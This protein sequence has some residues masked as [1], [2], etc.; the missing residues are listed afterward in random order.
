MF[1]LFILLL[2][3]KASLLTAHTSVDC[4]IRPL[5]IIEE[6]SGLEEVDAIYVINLEKRPEKWNRMKKLLHHKGLFPN[7]L[8][9]INGWLLDEKTK[10]LLCG[11]YPI[12]MRPGE[13]GVILS[14]LSIIHDAYK[15]GFD[16]IWVMEDD[17]DFREDI[18]QLPALIRELGQIDSHWDIF[19]TDTN[20]KNNKGEYVPS[21]GEDFRPD[22][23]HMDL[24]YYLKRTKVS[25]NIMKI[26]QRFGAYSMFVSSLGMKKIINY[27]NHYYF[28]TPYDIDIHYIPGIRQYATIKDIVSVLTIGE[29]DS[30]NERK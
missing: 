15:R 10:L 22:V 24:E 17:L 6:K 4:F 19:Y 25:D 14:H 13:M 5:P 11:H 27:F 30:R 8:S 16:C 21:L 28:W 3:V 29:S 12:R 2:F 7:R 23:P 9:A 1:F 20:S 26:G 18:Q